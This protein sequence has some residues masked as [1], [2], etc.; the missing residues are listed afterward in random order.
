MGR[1][2]EVLIDSPVEDQQNARVGRWYADAPDI[3]A[4]VYVTGENLVVGSFVRCEIVDYQN[5][6]LIAVA[7]GPGR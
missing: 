7:I 3:D 1:Q 4:A 2:V 6:D 5:Y